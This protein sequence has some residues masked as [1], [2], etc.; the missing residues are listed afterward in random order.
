VYDLAQSMGIDLRFQAVASLEGMYSPGDPPI[1]IVSALRPGGRQRLNCAHEIGH[2]LF[3]HGT[4]IDQ[5]I[6]ES[7]GPPRFDPDE[8]VVNCFAEYLLMPKLSVL[9]ALRT[10]NIVLDRVTAIEIFRA[11]NYFGVGYRTMLH[12]LEH[13]LGV[14]QPAPADALRKE[15][16]KSIRAGIIGREV[17][18]ELVV[19]DEAWLG[20]PIDLH[21]GDILLVPRGSL[22]EGKRLAE[23][24]NA[25]HGELYLATS[26]GI[27]RVANESLQWASYVRVSRRVPAGGFVGRSIYRHEEEDDQ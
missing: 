27:G 20:R 25:R 7:S 18:G 19:A 14:L 10:R 26:P 22:V 11:S 17:E 16:P 12:H 9:S 4:R 21:M 23:F 3:R 13:N 24:G 1:V 5:L 6:E 15:A 2:H 8:F